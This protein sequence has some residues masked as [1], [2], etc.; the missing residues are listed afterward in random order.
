M[1]CREDWLT[2][3][4]GDI[5]QQ[6]HDLKNFIVEGNIRNIRYLGDSCYLKNVIVPEHEPATMIVWLV[7]HEFHYSELVDSC[8][9]E[10]EK[11]GVGGILYLALNKF[12]AVPESHLEI[13]KNYDQAIF[14]FI[15]DHIQYPILKYQSGAHDYGK[16]F[17]WVH[18][19]TRFYFSS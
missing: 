13:D 7:N 4:A 5:I 19:L 11:L 8:N 18:P 12:L 16:Q 9:A 17:N 10:L 6:D 3:Y 2:W 14:D 1:S 15:S